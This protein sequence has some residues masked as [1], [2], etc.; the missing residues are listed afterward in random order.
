MPAQAKLLVGLLAVGLLTWLWLQ[1]FGAA[2]TVAE[3]IEIRATES[4]AA[5]GI[6]DVGIAVPRNP[7][8]RTVALTGDVPN[9]QRAEI[10]ETI[11]ALP[12]VADAVWEEPAPAEIAERTAAET[13]AA[14]TCREELETVIASHRIQFR[15]GSPYI[16]P[17]SQRLLD[18][19]AEAA[20]GCTGIR[21]EIAGHSSAGGRTNVNREMSAFRATTVRD[22]LIERGL[23]ADMF[24]TIGKGVSEPLDGNP[25]DPANRRIEFTV[26]LVD[27]EAG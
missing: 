2:S 7:V 10:R 14:Q 23:P 17:E 15:S 19:M 24:T 18:R 26:S 9:G 5:T 1:P 22:A 27:A 21:I 13:S 3:D 4:V 25:A 6:S 12:G 11:A 8:R 16:N 20:R